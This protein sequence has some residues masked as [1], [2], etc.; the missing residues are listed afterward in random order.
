MIVHVD[1]DAFFA[2]VEKLDNPKLADKCVIVG[3]T[4]GR[5]V[6][7]AA[8]YEARKYGVRSAMPVYKARRLCPQAVFVHPRKGRYKAVSRQVMAVLE[9]FS[10]LVEQVSID[11]AYLDITGCTRLLGDPVSAGKNIRQTIYDKTGLTCSVGIAP[12]KFLAKI[13]SDMKKPDGL[14][15][16]DPEQADDFIKSLPVS[17]V[18]GVGRV[19]QKTL[20]HMGISTLGDVKRYDKALIESKLGRFGIRIHELACGIDRSRVIPMRPVKSVSSELTL[21]KDS[22]DKDFLKKYL[23]AQ[24]EDVGRQL[25]RNRLKARTVFIKIKHSDFT[26]ATRQS[27]MV[28]PASCALSLYK[29]AVVLLDS[30]GLAKPVRLVGMGATDLSDQTAPVQQNLFEKTEQSTVKWEK[31]DTAMDAICQKFGSRKIT[32]AA[33]CLSCVSGSKPRRK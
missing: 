29:A 1:M 17:K 30:Y 10:P 24:A 26:Q 4:S 21:E 19:A 28:P 6:V 31:L 20:L 3:G 23:L 33:S 2:S 11:E 9:T 22:L 8:C 18:S 32:R 15:F 25:R 27:P 14:V 5:G 7:S 13:A 16:I 12:L